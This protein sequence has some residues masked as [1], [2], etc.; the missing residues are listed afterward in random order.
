MLIWLVNEHGPY[1]PR[2]EVAMFLKEKA[3]SG[4]KKGKRVRD[5]RVHFANERTFLAWV[6]T[7]IGI[8]AFGFFI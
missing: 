3:L 4:D 1:R 5:R 8:L 2:W 7:A 6:R